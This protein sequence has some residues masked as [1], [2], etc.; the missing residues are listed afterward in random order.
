MYIF[1]VM[2][3][4]K[5]LE[6][7]FR[8]NFSLCVMFFFFRKNTAYIEIYYEQLNFETL[9]ETAGYSVCYEL[10]QILK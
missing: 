9:R 5:D 4:S 3:S 6:G 8:I 7:V 1:E 10:I 2:Y